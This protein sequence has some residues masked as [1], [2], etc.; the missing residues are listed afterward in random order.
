MNKQIIITGPPFTGKGTI[1]TI[2]E[3]IMQKAID[4]NFIHLSTGE[5]LRDNVKDNTEL[6]AEAKTYMDSGKLVPDELID[7]IVRAALS[8]VKYENF[9]LDGYPRT[10]SQSESFVNLMKRAGKPIDYI[11]DLYCSKKV[12]EKRVSGRRQ[13][14]NDKCGK[15][16]NLYIPDFAPKKSNACDKCG[17]KLTRRADDSLDKFRLRY[18]IYKK[19]TEPAMSTL[20]KEYHVP[21]IRVSSEQTKEKTIVDLCGILNICGKTYSKFI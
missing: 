14:S 17:S 4:K 10:V 6:G 13:C 11:I 15:S 19:Q 1:A 9:L 21:I 3:K 16:Y 18:D 2:V 5:I 12:L 20:F 7:K 8:E